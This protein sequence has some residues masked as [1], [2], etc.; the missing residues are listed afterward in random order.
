MV[1]QSSNV[2]VKSEVNPRVNP[3]LRF[4]ETVGLSGTSLKSSQKIG[5]MEEVD[6]DSIMTEKANQAQSP[7]VAGGRRQ[8]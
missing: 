4:G 5:K 1:S 8:P 7:I 6:T 3:R 2:E